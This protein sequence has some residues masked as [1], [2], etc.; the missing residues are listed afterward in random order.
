MKSNVRN[1]DA[2]NVGTS[3]VD[4]ASAKRK[5]VVMDIVGLSFLFVG[6]DKIA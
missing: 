5:R 3:E 4:S 1:S 2:V 6:W